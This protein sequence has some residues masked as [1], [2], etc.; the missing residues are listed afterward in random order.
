MANFSLLRGA[1]PSLQPRQAEIR[2]TA[3]LAASLLSQSFGGGGRGSSR[4]GGAVARRS[5]SKTETV[6]EKQLKLDAAR[7]AIAKQ[8]SETALI[9]AQT[10]LAIAARK[11]DTTGYGKALQK[12]SPSQSQAFQQYTKNLARGFLRQPGV[13]QAVGARGAGSAPAKVTGGK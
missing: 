2:D 6:E 8:E 3:P 13:A 7:G 4:G 1:G 11:G 10:Q 12:V 9:D 5:E